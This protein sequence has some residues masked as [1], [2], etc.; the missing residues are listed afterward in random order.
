[1]E[2]NTQINTK[3]TIVCD[4]NIPLSLVDSSS[5]QNVNRET[6]VSND[7]LHQMALTNIYKYFTKH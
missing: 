5:G 3:P 7:I 6:P 1:M 2:F 4:L